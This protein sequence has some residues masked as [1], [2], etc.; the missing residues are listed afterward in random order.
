MK[1]TI[2]CSTNSLE[3]PNPSIQYENL[4][5]KIREK[6]ISNSSNAN[7]TSAQLTFLDT[8]EI[9]NFR[10]ERK[11]P[12]QER[13]KIILN[14]K[15]NIEVFNPDRFIYTRDEKTE[16]MAMTQNYSSFVTLL[17]I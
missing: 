7:N 9:E 12:P 8:L 5:K 14:L 16:G 2:E 6:M 15:L 17:S 3:S 4:I 11:I 1:S 13:D 10:V